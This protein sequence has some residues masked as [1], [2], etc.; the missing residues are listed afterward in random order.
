MGG[1]IWKPTIDRL[2]Q[3]GTV[4]H[5]LT[6]TGLEPGVAETDLAGVGL[7]DHVDD[8][9]RAVRSIDG[10]AIAVGHS[11]SG[12]LAGIVADRLPDQVV[13]TVIVAGFFPRHGRSLLD[14]WGSSSDERDAERAN[15]ERAGMVWTPPP[16]EGIAAD[17]GL[18]DSQAQWLGDRLVPHPGRTILDP[19]SMQRPITE[20]RVTVV[21]NVGDADPRSS[22]PDDLAHTEL[23]R[24]SFAAVPAGHWPMLSCPAELDGALLAAASATTYG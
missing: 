24:W 17:D 22:L 13:G 9:V 3:R 10:P 1:W 18:D 6:L 7:D 19:A 8:V 2:E 11:Y 5:T 23:D 21:A 12:V 20:Q 15:I 14:D 16:T 4:A